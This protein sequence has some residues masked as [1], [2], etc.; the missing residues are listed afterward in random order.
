MVQRAAEP[1]RVPDRYEVSPVNYRSE[2]R[3]QFQFPAKLVIHD[4]TIR[5][6]DHTAGTLDDPPGAKVEIARLLAAAGVHELGTNPDQYEGTVKHEQ[7]MGGVR[8]ISKAGLKIKVRG[9]TT[10]TDK[11]RR[12][13][14]RNID[15]IA[16]LGVDAIDLTAPIDVSEEMER[17]RAK[18][19]EHIRKKNL[20]V[21]VLVTSIG[22]WDLDVLIKAMNRWMDYGISRFHLCDHFSEV[23]PEGVRF[24]IQ[25]IRKG[26]KRE[27]PLLYHA[28]NSFGLATA[29][30]LAATSAGAWPETTVNGFGDRG[31]ASFEELVLALEMLYGVDTGIK[32]ERL[33]ELCRAVERITRLK[34]H[35]FKPVVGDSVWQAHLVTNYVD[36]LAGKNSR[37]SYLQAFEPAV[38]GGKIEL[39]MST[40]VLG[41]D[42]IRLRLDRLGLKYDADDLKAI[43]KAIHERIR[44]I[45]E[46]PAWISDSEVEE[47]ARARVSESVR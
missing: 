1:W 4:G 13:D 23:G 42:I 11:W 18:A 46:Y 22:Q 30:A 19:S 7:V 8:D 27:A 20:D 6:I 25:Y 29:T 35:P 43:V 10:Q 21:G 16:E 45:P 44:A 37:G 15:E 9:H 3:S 14:Y 41:P 12:G 34:N 5:K 32:M 38:V 40:N 33:T 39:M 17:A 24:V 36:F 26:L 47:I 28:H 31:F 2:V